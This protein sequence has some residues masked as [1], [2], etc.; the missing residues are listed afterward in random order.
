MS[1]SKSDALDQLGES[2]VVWRPGR[3]LNPQHSVLETDALP[4]ELPSH[5]KIELPVDVDLVTLSYP[6]GYLLFKTTSYRFSKLGGDGEI[7]THGPVIHKS[8]V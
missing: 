7:R 5:I 2:P 6:C 3:D 8:T 1:E 4:I